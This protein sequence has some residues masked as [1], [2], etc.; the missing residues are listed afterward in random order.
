[1]IEMNVCLIQKCYETKIVKI[2][3]PIISG[4]NHIGQKFLRRKQIT[5]NISWVVFESK[6]SIL[7]DQMIFLEKFCI[8]I[9][10]GTH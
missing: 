10:C 1:M 8:E 9:G 5:E 7:F 6:K 2:S 3:L 4:K